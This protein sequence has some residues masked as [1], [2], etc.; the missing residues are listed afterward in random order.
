MGFSPRLWASL[1]PR[2]PGEPKPNHYREAARIAWQNRDQ[3]PNAWRIL[4]RG[5]CDGCALGTRGLRDWRRLSSRACAADRRSRTR[6][7]QAE[8]R[9][10]IT[11]CGPVGTGCA[12]SSAKPASRYIASSSLR[13]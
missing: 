3:L 12:L 2:H 11:V 13:V 7:P 6:R 9:P 4:T 8:R 5:T 1:V 10:T